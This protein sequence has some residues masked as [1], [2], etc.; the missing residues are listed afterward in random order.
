VTRPLPALDDPDTAEFR[1]GA[2]RG[3][4]RVPRCDR[5][6]TVIWY[7]RAHCPACGSLDVTW[8]TLPDPVRGTVY[9]FTVVRRHAHPFFAARTP[10]A[11]AWIDLD[12][13]PRVLSEVACADVEALRIGDRVAL[14]WED[15]EAGRVPVF[16]T[17]M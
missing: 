2:A 9:T 14:R 17:A 1:A 15:N 5:C 7:P 4:F 13:G 6:G 11:V 10:Y 3:E 8:E 12:G 16:A